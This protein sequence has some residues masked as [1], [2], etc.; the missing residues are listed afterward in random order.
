MHQINAG[1][2]ANASGIATSLKKSKNIGD[3]QAIVAKAIAA[4]PNFSSKLVRIIVI[5]IIKKARVIKIKKVDDQ[6][7]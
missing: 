5:P 1:K 4:F 7:K 2:Q 3:M 6:I